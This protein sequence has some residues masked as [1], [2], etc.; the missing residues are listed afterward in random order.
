M[1]QPEFDRFAARMRAAWDGDPEVYTQACQMIHASPLLCTRWRDKPG[2]QD[3][4]EQLLLELHRTEADALCASRNHLELT[5][6]RHMAV[7]L[8]AAPGKRAVAA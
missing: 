3:G 8:E 2:A 6:H 7:I 4:T 1:D 5:Q